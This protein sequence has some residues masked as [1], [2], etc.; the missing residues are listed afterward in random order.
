MDIKGVEIHETI[1]RNDQGEEVGKFA[2][3]VGGVSKDNPKGFMDNVVAEYTNGHK[4]N[5][6]IE[7]HL[8]NPWTRIVTTNLSSFPFREFTTDD[9]LIHQSFESKNNN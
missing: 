9:F 6:F 5:Q 7:I 1:I 3:L 2:V 4:H 8:D